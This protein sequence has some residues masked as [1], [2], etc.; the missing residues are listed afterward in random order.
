MLRSGATHMGIAAVYAPNS[1]YKVFW[2]LVL[3]AP[4]DK[5]G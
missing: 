3:A 4:D 1:K 2:S 5:R